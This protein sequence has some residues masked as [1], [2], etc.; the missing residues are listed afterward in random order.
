MIKPPLD[1]VQ[2]E[3]CVKIGLMPYEI[4]FLFNRSIPAKELVP[5]YK[6]YYKRYEDL[7]EK[8]IKRVFRR[9]G[10]RKDITG[11]KKYIANLRATIRQH[12]AAMIIREMGNVDDLI[13]YPIEDLYNHLTDQLKPGM[14]WEERKKWHIDHIKPASLFTTKQIKDCFS[15]NNLR[16]LWAEEN[17][18]KGRKY[19]Q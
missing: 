13:G 1:W 15:L 9:S 5:L 18:K 14:T 2:I 4:A 12:I 8:Y 10:Q 7:Y 3:S 11:R 19:E 17:L 16:P 6:K